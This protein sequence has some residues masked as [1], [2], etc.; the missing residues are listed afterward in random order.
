MDSKYTI[1]TETQQELK[2]LSKKEGIVLS[3]KDQV[4]ICV[5]KIRFHARKIRDI[6]EDK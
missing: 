2:A 6:F 3:Y 4:E 5:D 1:V